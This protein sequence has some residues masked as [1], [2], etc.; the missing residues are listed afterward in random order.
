MK[1]QIFT[2]EWSPLAVF[3]VA[4]IEAIKEIK[5]W[6]VQ[7]LQK[8]I[9]QTENKNYKT[10]QYMLNIWHKGHVYTRLQTVFTEAK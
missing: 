1:I 2:R 5:H 4:T 6:Q 9:N 10:R 8:E 3:S 7:A